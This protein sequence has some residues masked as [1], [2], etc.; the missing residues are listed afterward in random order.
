MELYVLAQCPVVRDAV[1]LNIQLLKE[2]LCG[3]VLFSGVTLTLLLSSPPLWCSGVLLS[4]DGLAFSLL[5][6]ESLSLMMSYCRQNRAITAAGR[7]EMG[8]CATQ[9]NKE[10]NSVMRR[11]LSLT[12]MSLPPLTKHV[13]RPCEK[14]KSAPMGVW[15]LCL[16]LEAW[17]TP[18]LHGVYFALVFKLPDA[19]G[20]PVWR[21]TVCSQLTALLHWGYT[22][23][24]ECHH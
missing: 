7:W 1:C 20:P 22:F 19:V 6:L 14:L 9:T 21:R 10:W 12:D 17:K 24:W 23:V 18:I 3:P 8:T 16:Y 11:Q 13:E 15:G 5:L 2:P 4:D